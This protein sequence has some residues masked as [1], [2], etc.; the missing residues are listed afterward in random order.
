[1]NSIIGIIAKPLGI[2]LNWLYGIT[3]IYGLAIIIFTIIVKA[4]LYPLYVK[5]TKSMAGMSKLQPK[6][7]VLQSKYANDKETLNIKMSELYKEEKVNPAAGC[8]PMLIQMPILFG[9]FALLRNPLAYINTSND[10]ML[11]AIHQSFLWMSDLSQPDKWILPIIAGIA[12]FISYAMSE[13]LNMG[14]DGMGG[15]S[16]MGGSG[17]MMKMMKYVFPVLIVLM[18]RSFP[19]GLTI[20]WAFSMIIQIAYNFGLARVRRNMLNESKE[21][22]KKK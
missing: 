8:F 15:T 16:G 6:I 3:G 21:G 7:K 17:G 4:C 9:L 20:Y 13:K 10:D 1:M 14:I 19:G 5:Q 2:L 22:K 12:T 18:G 11:F